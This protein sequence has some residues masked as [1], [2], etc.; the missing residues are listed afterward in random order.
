MEKRIARLL[1][2][3]YSGYIPHPFTT[4]AEAKDG[5]DA[6]IALAEIAGGQYLYIPQLRSLFSQ[7]ARQDIQE[8]YDGLNSHEMARKYGY[9]ERHVRS[10]LGK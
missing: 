1:A 6:I 9:S 3:R 8:R 2:E 10:I 7:C 5:L 4:I